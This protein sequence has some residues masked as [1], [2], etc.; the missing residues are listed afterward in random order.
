[1]QCFKQKDNPEEVVS[2]NYE[3]AKEI[4][5][6]KS[7]DKNKEAKEVIEEKSNK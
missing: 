4:E 2:N 3:K 6:D 1:M 5:N 7:N